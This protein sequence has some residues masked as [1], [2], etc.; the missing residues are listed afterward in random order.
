VLNHAVDRAGLREDGGAVRFLDEAERR[1][2]QRLTS[3]S[4]SAQDRIGAV[5]PGRRA[6]RPAL[7]EKNIALLSSVSDIGRK[8]L[9]T[10]GARAWEKVEEFTRLRRSPSRRAEAALKA[11]ERL[12]YAVGADA[13][14]PGARGNGT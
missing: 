14:S 9:R 10:T 8:T 11:L 2:F 6:R 7:R 3:V 12:G 1:F 4:V 5:G 13:H